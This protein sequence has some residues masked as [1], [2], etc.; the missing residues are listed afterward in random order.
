VQL[1]TRRLAIEI[2]DGYGFDAGYVKGLGVWA[3]GTFFHARFKEGNYYGKD[4]CLIDKG[5]LFSFFHYWKNLFE[6]V[7]VF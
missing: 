6:F 7:E 2:G 1:R 3:L 4:N 5:R